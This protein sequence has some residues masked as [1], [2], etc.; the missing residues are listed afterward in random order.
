MKIKITGKTPEMLNE[1]IVC[2]MNIATVVA[3]HGNI[4]DEYDISGPER[5]GKYWYR[6]DN[7]FVIYGSTNNWFAY[8]REEDEL[9]ITVEFNYRY[10]NNGVSDALAAVIALRIHDFVS[11]D[12]W[13]QNNK[14]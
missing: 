3:G 11:V 7:R 14:T 10:D 12:N 1:N 9:S 5:S 4:P 2:V 8:V 6:D 13:S